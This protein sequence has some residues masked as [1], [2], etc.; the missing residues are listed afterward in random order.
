MR[1][2]N[3]HG[4]VGQGSNCKNDHCDLNDGVNYTKLSM[5]SFSAFTLHCD[6]NG[7][8][9]AIRESNRS[10]NFADKV[11]LSDIYRLLAL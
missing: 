10:N 9:V 5:F 7:N 11:N 6:Y 4:N 1:N 3:F 2:P 8:D